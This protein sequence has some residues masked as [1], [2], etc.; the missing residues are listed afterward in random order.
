MWRKI[1]RWAGAN[2]YGGNGW[3]ATSPNNG[4]PRQ[5]LSLLLLPWGSFCHCPCCPC[6]LCCP[7]CHRHHFLPWFLLLL[8]VRPPAACL[9]S[10]DAGA[11][12]ASC[13]PAEP[14]LPLVARYFI[15][16]DCYLIVLAPTP[17][18]YYHSRHHYNNLSLQLDLGSF[19]LFWWKA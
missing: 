17:S 19:D 11:T 16:A 12:A 4:C 10:A 8:P 6:S 2:R 9:L 15:M 14:L 18:S 13:P 1:S 3:A 5:G 7:S